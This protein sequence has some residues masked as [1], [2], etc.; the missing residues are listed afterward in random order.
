MRRAR[1][2]PVPGGKRLCTHTG[3]SPYVR[4]QA[5]C[6]HN[7]RAHIPFVQAVFCVHFLACFVSRCV[8]ALIRDGMCRRVHPTVNC[9]CP[10]SSLWAC[11][12]ARVAYLNSEPCCRLSFFFP[13][14]LRALSHALMSPPAWK[15]GQAGP[16]TVSGGAR[17]RQEDERHHRSP[18]SSPGLSAGEA[19]KAPHHLP[20]RY[21]GY[22]R[23]PRYCTWACRRSIREADCFSA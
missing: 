11:N 4:S 8:C 21:I 5:T 15:V 7:T 19:Q 17:G 2:K 23:A 14:F 22:C 10:F 16:G 18:E 3:L 1:E 12:G 6:W 20:R 9:P 13:F